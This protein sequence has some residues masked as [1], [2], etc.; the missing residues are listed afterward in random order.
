MVA[1]GEE[2]WRKTESVEDAA[3]RLIGVMDERAKKRKTLAG[4][5]VIWV[6]ANFSEDGHAAALRRISGAV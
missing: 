4:W 5:G 3:R 2:D 1:D 6:P